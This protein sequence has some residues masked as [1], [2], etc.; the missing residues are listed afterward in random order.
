[1]ILIILTLHGVE[2]TIDIN[3]ISVSR[4]TIPKEV[5]MHKI[6]RAKDGIEI[7]VLFRQGQEVKREWHFEG[8]GID[9]FDAVWVGAGVYVKDGVR[10]MLD[11]QA[12]EC[13]D[14]PR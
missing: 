12:A 2:F 14:K 1:M 11:E 5:I 13:E 10:D 3:N 6:F 8:V 4:E 7:Q 9:E